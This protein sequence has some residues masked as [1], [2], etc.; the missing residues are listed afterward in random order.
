M[1]PPT[2]QVHQDDTHRLIP[3]KYLPKDASVLSRLAKTPRDL[4][5]LAE[6]EGATNDRLLGE[7]NRLPGISVHELVF[8]IPN[9]HI[10]NAAFTHAAPS[11]GRFNGSDRAAWYAGYTLE[12]SQ[13]E[14]AF[15]FARELREIPSW[16]EPETRSYRDYLAD[17][18]AEFHDLRN[19]P[20]HADALDPES[21]D[22]SQH[23][24]RTLLNRGSAGIVFPSVRHRGGTCIACFR[25]ALVTNVRE[26]AL[27]Q[28]GYG[29]PWQEPKISVE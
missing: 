10:I 15:H 24:A 3:T 25:P 14:V 9:Y 4:D 26:G 21:Y 20:G 17:F 16:K 7:A 11:G 27:V 22:A 23:L 12:T 1:L 29:D 13:Q 28:I 19:D 5:D 6:L 8:G 18:R 2:S